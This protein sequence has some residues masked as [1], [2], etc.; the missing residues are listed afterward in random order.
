MVI[1]PDDFMV[2][3]EVLARFSE[4]IGQMSRDIAAWI[5]VLQRLGAIEDLRALALGQSCEITSATVR[6]IIAA[7]RLRDRFFCPTMNER[8]WALLLELFAS[9]L[10]GERRDAAGLSEAT[11]Y[12]LASAHNWIDWLAD[13]GLVMRRPVSG[14]EEGAL[15]D[16]TDLGGDRMRTYLLESLK[17]SPW[18][19]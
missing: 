14:N 2:R 17:L 18:V 12:P 10:E 5:P 1:T 6:S 19:Q 16:L 3:D 8:A 4:S 13:Q 15:I 7:R 11:G 9:S